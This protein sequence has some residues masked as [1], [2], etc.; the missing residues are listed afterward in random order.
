MLWGV[1]IPISSG[2]SSVQDNIGEIQNRG[3]EFSISTIN[4]TNNNF[5]WNTDF[6]ISFNK[7]EVLDMGDVGRI[8]T[9]PRSYSLTTEGQPMAMFYGYKSLGILN[10]WEDVEKYP[11][12]ASQVPGTP[13]YA[14]SDK[15]GV[16]DE[17]DKVIIGNPHPKFRGGFN[18][19][20]KYK[21][22]DMNIAMSFAHDFD[23]WAQLEEDVINLDGVFNVLTEVKDRWRSPE[24]PG[25]GRIAASFHETAYDRWENSDWVHNASFLKVQNISVGYTFENVKFVKFLRLYG[26]VQNAFLFTNYRYGNPEA[27]VYGNNSLIRNF[28]NYDYPVARSV[29]F[30]LDLNF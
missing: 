6:N 9:G 11:H 4:I 3:V 29:I 15:N 23:I 22:W 14:D 1:A 16:L 17:R 21:S 27:S 13:H 8:L 5:T 10:T 25:N 24:Q 20:F 7:N 12:F 18:N 2:F 26:S 19:S 28:D 30:G